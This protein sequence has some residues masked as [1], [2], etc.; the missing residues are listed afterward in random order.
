FLGATGGSTAN[1]IKAVDYMTDLKTRQGIN[2]I[3]TNNSWGGGGY[4]Q[5]LYDAI[6]RANNAGIFFVAAAGNDS[7]STLSYPA[8]YDLPNVISVA[9]LDSNGALSSFSN[10][11]STWVDLGAPGGGIY[12]TLPDNT[13]GTY[14]GTSMATPHVTGALALMRAT[15]PGATMGQLKQALFDSV[16]QTSS[17]VW[18][19]RHRRPSGCQR[20][21][22][23][24]EPIVRPECCNLCGERSN[25]GG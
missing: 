17:P 4:T 5:G 25:P 11:S 21:P 3:A 13:Y 7:T 10:F 6:S 22:D 14:S 1:A 2:L 15:Y 18:Q 16:V 12:S 8:G 20:R 19:N 23:T 24:P 9:S